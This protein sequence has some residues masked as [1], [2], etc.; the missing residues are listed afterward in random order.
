MQERGEEEG[1]E[2][3]KGVVWRPAFSM[4]FGGFTAVMKTRCLTRV[5]DLYGGP[6]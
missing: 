4:G 3:W 1:R 5:L 2:G 6:L